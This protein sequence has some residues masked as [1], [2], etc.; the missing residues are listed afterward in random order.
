MSY[1]KVIKK[2]KKIETILVKM[3][4]E[5]KG[6]HEKVSSIEHLIEENTVKSIRFVASIRNKL[7]HEDDF[8]M[9]SELLLDFENACENIINTLEQD[10]DN[11]T[12]QN[13]N[14]ESSSS[15][16]SNSSG[17]DDFSTG[18]KVGIGAVALGALAVWSWFNA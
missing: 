16:S 18:E 4:A 14:S 3:G 1:K 8:E 7:L 2:T 6:L 12:Q 10:T 11:S 5:G 17:W 9:T 13:Y 15:S